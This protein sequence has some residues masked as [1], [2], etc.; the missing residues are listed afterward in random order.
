MGSEISKTHFQKSDFLKFSK[1]LKEE[2]EHCL[3]LA[4]NKQFKST[5]QRLGLELEACLLDENFLPSPKNLDFLEKVSSESAAAELAQFNVE[6]NSQVHD[7]GPHL[8]SDLYNEL[9]KTWKQFQT[10]A[11]ELACQLILIGTL[12]TIH[13][14]DLSLASITPLK[15]YRALNEQLIR[16]RKG[17]PFSL[18]I[19]GSEH[20]KTSHSDVVLESAATS[21]QIH[22]EAPFEEMTR[23]FNASLILSG[24]LL[25]LSANSPFLFQKSLWAETRIPVFEQVINQVTQN[26][27]HRDRVFF[28]ESFIQNDLTE[29]FLENFNH[30]PVILPLEFNSPKDKFKHLSLHN[31]T[32][33][34]WNRPI[35]SSEVDGPHMRL[36]QRVIAAGPSILDI[37][38]NI[39]FFLGSIQHLRSLS[40]APEENFPFAFAKNN[41]YAC[42]QSGMDAQ[43]SWL[44]QKEYGVQELLSNELL[45]QARQGLL[46]MGI[47]KEDIKKYFDDVIPGRV[48]KKQNGAQW[49]R[50]FIQKYGPDFQ[51]MT[52]K[53][54]EHQNSGIPVH[55]WSL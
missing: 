36:E 28:G 14:Q 31:G 15:R 19:W 33:W 48:T 27:N 3:D 38:G 18:D 10:I 39:A 47:L 17:K 1:H 34:R 55:S 46:D 42:A 52:Q 9:D 37:V 12:P 54:L 51:T 21:L 32:L 41:F 16:L 24:P 26:E 50:A 35:L 13:D 6:F 30:Y 8:L 7:F 20:L 40:S 4:K 29:L 23:L 2:T 5:Q 43:I 53:Y 45:P 49:Q 44:D 25:A 11:N 22:W